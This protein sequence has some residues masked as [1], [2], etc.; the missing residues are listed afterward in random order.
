MSTY[1]RS[2]KWVVTLAVPLFLAGRSAGQ[3]VLAPAPGATYGAPVVTYYQAPGVY[4]YSPSGPV[5]VPATTI[6]T[7][8]RALLP[9]NRVRVTTYVP[10]RVVAPPAPVAPPSVVVPAPVLRPQPAPVYP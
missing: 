7:Y 5:T 9:R 1:V 6:V 10:A 8:R 4:Y 2:W 3:T